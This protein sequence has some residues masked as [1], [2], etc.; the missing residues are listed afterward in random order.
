MF[1]VCLLLI[2]GPLG[3][4]REGFSLLLWWVE[5]LPKYQRI[6]PGRKNDNIPDDITE[7]KHLNLQRILK[8]SQDQRF[9]Q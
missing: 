2:Q 3:K 5:I 7:L 8:Q 6:W 1:F 9:I 4:K